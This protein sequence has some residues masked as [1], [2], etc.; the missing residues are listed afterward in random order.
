MGNPSNM[1]CSVQSISL[2]GQI[3]E[4]MVYGT[5]KRNRVMTIVIPGNPGQGEYYQK[6]CLGLCEQ[7]GY[8]TISLSYGNFGCTPPQGGV[9]S[10]EIEAELKRL[11]LR[12]LVEDQG[13]TLRLVGHS[14]GSWIVLECLKDPLIRTATVGVHLLFPF[15]ACNE[16][17]W[18][19]QTIGRLLAL[20]VAHRVSLGLVRMICILPW[21]VRRLLLGLNDPEMMEEVKQAT[22]KGI[23]AKPWMA[24]SIFEMGHTEFLALHA[25]YKTLKAAATQIQALG[26]QGIPVH[27]MYA[28]SDHWA[29]SWQRDELD[30]AVQSPQYH[31]AL[32]P[33]SHAYVVYSHDTATVLSAWPTVP[34]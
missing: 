23:L 14:I 26:D 24:R 30:A 13:C 6:F 25:A 5:I 20:P 22:L 1:P 17:S 33:V 21:A 29:P 28:P 16:R 27:A 2:K 9:L 18:K 19:Q 34:P 32:V 31:S 3:H 8:D 11:Q 10:I 7:H 12:A 15:L 4:L